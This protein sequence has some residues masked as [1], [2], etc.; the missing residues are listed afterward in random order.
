MEEKKLYVGYACRKI[1]PPLGTHIPG[2]GFVPRPSTGVIDDVY[3]YAIAFSDGE[4][5]AILFNC[6]VLGIRN[7]R[8]DK[9]RQKVAERVGTNIDHVM[10]ATTHCHTSGWLGSSLSAE[11]PYGSYYA[12]QESI[13]ADLAQFAV[14]DLKPATMK[15]A[16]GKVEG[17]GYIRRYLLADGTFKTN[18]GYMRPD[19]VGPDGVQDESLQLVRFEREGGKEIVLVN[20]GTHPDVVSGTLYTPDWP[21]YVVRFLKGALGE[22]SEVVMLNGF[23]GDSNHINRFKPKPTIPTLDFAK[24]MARKVAGEALKVYDD[25]VELP[26]GKVAGLS[27]I[28]SVEQNPH[29]DWEVPIAR[30]IAAAGV[31]SD[32][33][34]PDELRAYKISLKKAYRILNNLEHEGDYLI[35]VYAIQVGSLAFVGFPGEPFSETGMIVK[36]RS[37]KEMTMCCCRANGAY[38]YFPT[39]RAYEGAGYE[40]EYTK[41]GP[42]CSEKLTDAA[43]EILEEMNKED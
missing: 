37:C 9:I 7:A 15:G 32:K 2:H 24:G 29:E 26:V 11:E 41:L 4:N 39:R 30:Q 14:E 27:K 43:I 8:G 31:K 36:E 22:S 18:P 3:A 12:M 1:T 10:V 42:N 28:A 20:F 23:G 17:V 25:A 34:L 19:I 35:P 16:R 40:R 5:K 21:G 33:E 6:D 38:G 13:L